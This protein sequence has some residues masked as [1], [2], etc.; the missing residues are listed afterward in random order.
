MAAK[1][2]INGNNPVRRLPD[3]PSAGG[4]MASKLREFEVRSFEA[5]DKFIV[6]VGEKRRMLIPFA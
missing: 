1:I 2:R 3:C 5:K 6:F 4:A